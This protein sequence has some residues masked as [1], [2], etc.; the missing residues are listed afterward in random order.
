MISN[1][2]YDLILSELEK[3]KLH[4]H[5]SFFR[6]GDDIASTLSDMIAWKAPDVIT[7]SAFWRRRYPTTTLTFSVP[8]QVDDL[9]KRLLD[10]WINKVS[11]MT[12]FNP[13]N[14]HIGRDVPFEASE[15]ETTQ[16]G[17]HVIHLRLPHYKFESGTELRYLDKPIDFLKEFMRDD[18][19][20]YSL[21]LTKNEW[22]VRDQNLAGISSAETTYRIEIVRKDVVHELK[23]VIDVFY[24]QPSPPPN[25][26][27][28]KRK[29][30]QKKA[31]I[32][33]EC[34]GK[35]FTRHSCTQHP[36]SNKC[37]WAT[38]RERSF[39]RKITTKT[40]RHKSAT[41]IQ[42][43]YRKKSNKTS[44]TLSPK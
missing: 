27:S 7:V 10:Q 19:K 26:S 14:D 24:P 17:T 12:S 41:R 21:K 8:H 34:S 5:R 28:T 13:K 43:H 44:H 36:R 1:K 37:Q 23:K 3:H 25:H 30:A 11:A 18:K 40:L 42:S 16:K 6:G 15:R 39:C 4:R 38:G 33:S 2:Q 31:L 29:K 20:I 9:V 32:K 22:I 35:K